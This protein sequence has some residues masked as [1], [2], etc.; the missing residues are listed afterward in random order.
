[1]RSQLQEGPGHLVEKGRERHAVSLTGQRQGTAVFPEKGTER[2]GVVFV[3][4]TESH[5]ASTLAFHSLI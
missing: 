4:S 3:I 2:R 1:M 5:F